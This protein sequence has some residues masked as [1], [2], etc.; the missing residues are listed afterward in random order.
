MISVEELYDYFLYIT[1][2]EDI[3]HSYLSEETNYMLAFNEWVQTIN[4]MEIE[5]LFESELDEL[6]RKC[7]KFVESYLEEH[8]KVAPLA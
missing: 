4:V 2:E 3:D 6:K 1:D 5:E 8:A 7:S